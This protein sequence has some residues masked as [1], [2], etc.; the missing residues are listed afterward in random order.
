MTI[1]FFIFDEPIPSCAIHELQFA[2]GKWK[3]VYAVKLPHEIK[4]GQKNLGFV[5]YEGISDLQLRNKS[6]LNPSSVNIPID[7]YEEYIGYLDKQRDADLEYRRLYKQKN[8]G[9]KGSTFRLSN[10]PHSCNDL[11]R[12]GVHNIVSI[13]SQ[14]PDETEFVGF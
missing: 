3:F 12:M 5:I 11:K 6:D 1:Q 9:K 8:P 14:E 2:D 4:P 13:E 10:M 7:S